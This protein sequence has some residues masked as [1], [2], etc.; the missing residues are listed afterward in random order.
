MNRVSL[1]QIGQRV[2]GDKKCANNDT[3]KVVCLF[4]HTT[5]DVNLVFFGHIYIFLHSLNLA[6]EK[7]SVI[8]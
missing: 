1:L 8:V 2:K 4:W 5:E 3:K 6:S 7:M